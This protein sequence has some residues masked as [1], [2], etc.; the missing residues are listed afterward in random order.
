MNTRSIFAPS[1]SAIFWN[2]LLI[3]ISLSKGFFSNQICCGT[4]ICNRYSIAE[5]HGNPAC[6]IRHVVPCCHIL[7]K[8]RSLEREH[9]PLPTCRSEMAVAEYAWKIH[10]PQVPKY[11]T[12]VNVMT[13]VVLVE[14]RKNAP[15]Q[16]SQQTAA[17]RRRKQS[18]KVEKHPQ[19]KE[20]CLVLPLNSALFPCH[21]T[22]AERA[23]ICLGRPSGPLT[24]RPL[25]WFPL[26]L[27]W[28][29]HAGSFV[30][31]FWFH[32]KF[33]TNRSLRNFLKLQTD[34][35]HPH[36]KTEPWFQ[37]SPPIHV[38]IPFQGTTCFESN[39]VV[40]GCLLYFRLR[41]NFNPYLFCIS[42][43]HYAKLRERIFKLFKWFCSNR[44]KSVWNL[45]NSKMPAKTHR[46]GQ[47]L[48]SLP[49]ARESWATISQQ[50]NTSLSAIWGCDTRGHLE[51][52]AF[53]AE[54]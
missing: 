36:Y 32:I 39:F 30:V 25:F 21:V 11:V 28:V 41:S 24:A 45:M 23:P 13:S 4:A 34:Q 8:P 16:E 2:S 5:I 33:A 51:D 42:L 15:A 29:G 50:A 27:A 38:L 52:K 26:K 37:T 43:T 40:S 49:T 22:L 12:V 19:A 48:C 31:A 18:S 20:G 44:F 17:N 10:A 35:N 47:M 9:G 3:V 7:S 54:K 6:E 53:T 1:N 14:S 46:R